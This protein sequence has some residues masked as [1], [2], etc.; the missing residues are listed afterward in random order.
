M[1]KSQPSFWWRSVW[2]CSRGDLWTFDPMPFWQGTTLFGVSDITCFNLTLTAHI[3]YKCIF[4]EQKKTQPEHVTLGFLCRILQTYTHHSKQAFE[5]IP[6]FEP[7]SKA[8]V[9]GDPWCLLA[10]WYSLP[11]FPLAWLTSSA[12]ISVCAM[13]FH[14][15]TLQP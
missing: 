10:F 14:H 3:H 6:C 9:C 11:L 2:K 7:K 12:V 4:G 8:C 15:F 5:F 13:R 1:E